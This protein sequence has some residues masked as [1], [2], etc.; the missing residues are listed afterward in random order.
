M[1]TLYQNVY[2]YNLMHNYITQCASVQ[3]SCSQMQLQR[4]TVSLPGGTPDPFPTWFI[5]PKLQEHLVPLVHVF[6]K[7][8]NKI[9]NI[10]VIRSI[11][12]SVKSIRF[13]WETRPNLPTEVS[14]SASW[15]HREIWFPLN[16]S[17]A[18]ASQ[19]YSEEEV[20]QFSTNF[21]ANDFSLLL[22]CSYRF[23]KHSVWDIHWP[24]VA[25]TG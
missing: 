5:L 18:F 14:L 13:T 21:W 24:H 25:I 6:R 3:D 10:K 16:S 11:N 9:L 2:Q 4:S 22:S 1:F 7:W 19:C 17:G 8:K 12:P 15:Q 23:N 20:S